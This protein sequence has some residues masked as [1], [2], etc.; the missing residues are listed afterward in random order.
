M[1][2]PDQGA[3]DIP[4]DSI[5]INNASVV[6]DMKSIGGSYAGTMT[7]DTTLS[8]KWSQKEM[9]FPLVLKRTDKPAEI[10]RPKEPQPPY[11]Y[12]EEEVSY[13]NAAA[14]DT[15][16]G[17]FTTP[18]S[19][20]PFAAVLL[21]T[22][23]GPQNRNEALMGHKPFL[24]LADYLTRLGIAVLRVD[25][26]GIGKSTGNFA[27]AT[28]EDFAADVQAGVRYLKARKEIDPRKIGLIGHSEGGIIAPMVAAESK[29]IAFI[30]MMAGTGVTGEEISLA[31]SDLIDKANGMP[32][33]IIK[34]ESRINSSIFNIVK[35]EQDTA[36]VAK[37]IREYITQTRKNMTEKEQQDLG[38]VDAAIPRMI[39]S[40]SSPWFK[41][42]LTYD[43]QPALRN[44]KCPVLAINGGKDLQVPPDLNLPKIEEALTAGG[45]TH[46][47]I[48]KLPGLNHLF[49]TCATGSPT[50]YSKIEETISPLALKT[51]G[52]WILEVIK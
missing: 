10:H 37:K 30:V 14:G 5:I 12:D 27:I 29:D 47:L 2:S 6:I 17:T 49:Q 40:V 11:P 39:K 50:E 16:S 8:G 9:S 13:V 21:V 19:G 18:K 52:D 43:P 26:R 41:Y 24:V 20:G 33:E 3:K 51:M 46:Y 45:N 7:N 35:H 15:L 42:F 48:K 28:T 4:C 31:Q 44:V 32:D 23:S 36:I 22:G 25:D 34:K 1:D 38:L